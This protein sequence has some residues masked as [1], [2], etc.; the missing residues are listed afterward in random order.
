MKKF[1]IVLF[2][3]ILYCHSAIA[4]EVIN[5][6]ININKKNIIISIPQSYYIDKSLSYYE[7]GFIV[8][9]RLS[10]NSVISIHTGA[11]L[12]FSLYIKCAEKSINYRGICSYKG[13]YKNMPFRMDIYDKPNMVILYISHKEIVFDISDII[14]DNII[15]H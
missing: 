4:Q 15:I 6:T 3:L 9:Y 7:E 10:N 12:D 14:M 8:T 5:D 2:I 13:K 11:M 1:I